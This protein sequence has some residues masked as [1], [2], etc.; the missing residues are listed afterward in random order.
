M[1][2]CSCCCCCCCSAAP[3]PPRPAADASH[4]PLLFPAAGQ[5]QQPLRV[6]VTRRFGK[7]VFA[8]A[9]EHKILRST[10]S[11]TVPSYRCAMPGSLCFP[12]LRPVFHMSTPQPLRTTRNMVPTLPSSSAALPL[13]VRF[14]MDMIATWARHA[15]LAELSS[16]TCAHQRHHPPR[17]LLACLTLINL[18]LAAMLKC[19]VNRLHIF[20]PRSSACVRVESPWRTGVMCNHPSSLTAA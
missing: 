13:L 1:R 5:K 15:C 17:E 9:F 14:Q 10:G 8:T 12:S 19:Y 18:L 20:R 7:A 6:P 4:A 2:C 3:P 11:S 16:P